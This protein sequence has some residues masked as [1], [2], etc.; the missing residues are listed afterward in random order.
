MRQLSPVKGGKER[1][2]LQDP[3]RVAQSQLRACI[4]MYRL[5]LKR[6]QNQCPL[7]HGQGR[8]SSTG[9]S[10]HENSFWVFL[11]NFDKL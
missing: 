11:C 6:T 3:P 1:I 2:R 5:V 10:F 8:V 4:L 7:C 9:V